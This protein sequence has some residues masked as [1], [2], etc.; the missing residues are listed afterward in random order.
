MFEHLAITASEKTLNF[1][2][3]AIR[4]QAEGLKL[5]LHESM[6][7]IRRQAELAPERGE[8]VNW[9]WFEDS[10][11]K[12]SPI[13]R[14]VLATPQMRAAEQPPTGVD[15]ES[16]DRVWNGMSKAAKGVVGPQCF[17]TWIRPI[18]AKGILDGVLY[19]QIPSDDFSHVPA[20]YDFAQYLP[21]GVNEVRILNGMGVAA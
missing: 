4:M 19:L 8:T 12:A 2:A 14:Q 16:G 20:R 11:W 18:K 17:D 13:E 7:R 10:R 3:E 15:I 21:A 9:M 1:A 5:S 6:L